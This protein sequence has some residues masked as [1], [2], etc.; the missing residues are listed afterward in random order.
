MDLSEELSRLKDLAPH[1]DSSVDFDQYML[2]RFSAIV[3]PRLRGKR[4]LD[5]GCSSGSTS[6]GL[7]DSAAS[8]DLVDGSAHYLNLARG[9]VKGE[10]VRFFHSL[11]EE[12]R[13]DRQYDHIIC[14]HVLEHVADPIAVLTVAKR[15]LADGGVLWAFVPNAQSIHRLLGVA[16]GLST[17]IYELS[18]RDHRIGHRRVYDASALSEDIRAAGLTHG[19]VRGI[20]LKPLPTSMMSNFTD[21]LVQ[22]F[23]KL[24]AQLPDYASDIYYE[25]AVGSIPNA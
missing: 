3:A 18:E 19:P 25:C 6:E 10:H 16:M 13:P 5:L 1:Y 17:S 22:G 21:E 15:W 2:K 23:L 20:M 24:G 4:V 7:A 8:L 9:R 12:Y 11:F 14:S